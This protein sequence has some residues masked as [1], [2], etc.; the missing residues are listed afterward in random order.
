MNLLGAFIGEAIIAD[1]VPYLVLINVMLNR[2]NHNNNNSNHHVL[3]GQY[4][5]VEQNNFCIYKEKQGSGSMTQ[6]FRG[7]RV[8]L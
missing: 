6:E 5:T 2:P 8:Y 3:S 7:K 4:F 1:I